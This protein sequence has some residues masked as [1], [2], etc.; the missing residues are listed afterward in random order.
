MSKASSNRNA[1]LKRVQVMNGFPHSS[2]GM[3]H[4]CQGVSG[5]QH[6]FAQP[7]PLLHGGTVTQQ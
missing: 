5:E 3:L 4:E 7:F 2:L 6:V 1:T